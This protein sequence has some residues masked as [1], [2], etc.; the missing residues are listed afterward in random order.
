MHILLL[1]NSHY[2]TIRDAILG[3]KMQKFVAIFFILSSSATITHV[4]AAQDSEIVTG[5]VERTIEPTDGGGGA[6]VTFESKSEFS[7]D[8]SIR[9]NRFTEIDTTRTQ[10]VETRGDRTVTMSME[11]ERGDVQVSVQLERSDR[12]EKPE[13]PDRPR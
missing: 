5:T 4:A 12:T 6:A 9:G 2:S 13:K 3:V 11:K 10:T 8:L 7:R 1:P